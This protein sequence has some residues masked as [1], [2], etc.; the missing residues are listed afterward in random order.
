MT[1]ILISECLSRSVRLGDRGCVWACIH[2]CAAHKEDAFVVFEDKVITEDVACLAMEPRCNLHFE[3]IQVEL[4]LENR[5]ERA[6]S[7][8]TGEGN[9]LTDHLSI[10]A[11]SK[12]VDPDVVHGFLKFIGLR[13]NGTLFLG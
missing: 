13:F 2:G 7:G 6:H 4:P 12:G 3:H 10:S 1:K 11:R 8:R 9:R 5:T